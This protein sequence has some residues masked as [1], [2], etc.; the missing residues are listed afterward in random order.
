MTE[1]KKLT[2]YPSID[3]PW[4]K[5]YSEEAISAPLP[6]GSMYDYMCACNNNRLNAVALNYFGNKITHEQL[7]EN[8]DAC[9]K[10]LT[11]NGVKP[12]DYVSLCMLT[13]P[14]TVY[15]L[16]AINKIGAIAN[17]IVL[18]ATEQDIHKQIAACNSSLVITM[19]LAEE[20]IVRAVKNTDVVNIVSVSLAQSMP[21]HLA[22]L[23]KLKKQK[24]ISGVI[25]WKNFLQCGTKTEVPFYKANDKAPAVVEYTGGTTGDSKGVIL[26]NQAGNALAFHYRGADTVCHFDPGFNPGERFLNVLPPFLAYGLY[27][28]I[29]L[30]LCIG[31]ENILSPDPSPKNFPNLV[32][33]YKPN[34]FAAGP[35]HIDCMMNDPKIRESDLSYLITVAFGGD[36]ASS[37]WEERV[38]SFLEDHKA[39]Y[40]V[41]NGYGMTELAG[42]FCTSTHKLRALIPFVKNNIKII[43]VD[44]G[45]ELKYGEEGEICVSGPSMMQGYY[46]N[47]EATNST[48]WE[49]NGVRWL[50]TGDLGYVTEEG[51]FVI[52]GRLKRIFCSAG[53]DDVI[54]RVYPT[55]IEATITQ[56]SS[57][58]KCSV[59]GKPNGDKGYL[60]VA[61]IVLRDNANQSEALSQIKNLCEQEL[62]ETSRPTKY[63]I[64]NTLPTTGAGKVDYRALEKETERL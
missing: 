53:S 22:L 12:G 5:Y 16:Y 28:G 50:H 63:I 40:G 20:K 18:N 7:R 13:V 21:T 4:L 37:E 49:E 33:K 29:H 54:Y 30:P 61:F 23:L 52:S 8:I 17:F 64:M 9:A 46:K 45:K 43:D 26:S 24:S 51:Y 60:P 15:L 19:N 42:T 10:A 14:E 62:P 6:T 44:S 59:V 34:H 39:P 41:I 1:E 35:M 32:H 57:V 11:A 38:S 25:S 36:K 3:K 31:M 48:I 58:Q 27:V 56:C 55:K 47:D 2:G